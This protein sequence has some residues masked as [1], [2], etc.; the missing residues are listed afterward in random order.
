M[1]RYMPR[2]V[3][4]EWLVIGKDHACTF[5]KLLQLCL[6]P[7]DS[8]DQRPHKYLSKENWTNNYGSST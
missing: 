3:I 6:T 5:A 2:L 4:A 8:M 7:C 1:K